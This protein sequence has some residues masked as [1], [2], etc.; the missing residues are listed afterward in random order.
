M[1]MKVDHFAEYRRRSIETVRDVRDNV[2]VIEN[3]KETKGFSP[4]TSVTRPSRA[5]RDNV[6]DLFEVDVVHLDAERNARDRSAGRGYDYLPS[7]DGFNCSRC[8]NDPAR[9]E[10][11][12]DHINDPGVFHCGDCEEDK[13]RPAHR[14]HDREEDEI[15]RAARADGW[16]PSAQVAP[17]VAAEI[18]RIEAQALAL[19]WTLGRLWNFAFWPHRGDEPRGLASVMNDGDRIVEVF[20]DRIVME[21]TVIRRVRQTFWRFQ[22]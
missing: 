18:H 1:A 13:Q 14:I 19:G 11:C 4:V 6:T 12:A 10:W 7:I 2:T 21:K 3:S 8:L 15:D 16:Q 22:S 20:A 17:A 9:C 5:S